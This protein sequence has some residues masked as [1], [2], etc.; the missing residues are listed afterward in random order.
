MVFV[1]P[2]IFTEKED[3]SYTGYFPDLDDLEV[4]GI[5]LLRAIDEARDAM[6]DRIRFELTEDEPELPP[7]SEIDEKTLAPNQ[8][9]VDISIHY[10]FT[11]GWDE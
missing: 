9:V 7:I 4:E 5:S 6:Y 11:D 8:K 1:Y 10:R 3:G 2:A